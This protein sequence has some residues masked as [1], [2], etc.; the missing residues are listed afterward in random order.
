MKQVLHGGVA[1]DT[2][3][4]RN[5][6]PLSGHRDHQAWGTKLIFECTRWAVGLATQRGLT[7]PRIAS[8]IG[9]KPRTLENA[10]KPSEERSLGFG[11]FC[12]LMSPDGPLPED[13][14]RETFSRFAHEF[15]YA[16]APTESDPVP[17]RD[18]AM[19]VSASVGRLSEAVLV[20]TD[21][22]SPGGEAIT[23]GERVLISRTAGDVV[24]A[25]APLTSPL[26]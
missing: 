15:G 12:E 21:A 13:I 16:I 24:A 26:A 18:A 4:E 11:A 14:R 2:A 22:C 6:R 17:A 3:A 19:A 23:D 9:I 25:V 1:F 10:M 5:S 7:R 20:A 8:A